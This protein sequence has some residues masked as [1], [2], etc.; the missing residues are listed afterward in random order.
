MLADNNILLLLR[1]RKKELSIKACSFIAQ[2]ALELSIYSCVF[3]YPVF[4][5]VDVDNLVWVRGLLSNLSRLS[6]QHF[7]YNF[8]F[9]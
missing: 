4:S 9:Y 2:A 1:E 8:V 6:N 3:Q 5:G 7:W